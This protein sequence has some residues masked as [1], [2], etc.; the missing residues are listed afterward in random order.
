VVVGAEQPHAQRQDRRIRVGRIIG[1]ITEGAITYDRYV[2]GAAEVRI[3]QGV[4]VSFP[5]R[6][7][8]TFLKPSQ[9]VIVQGDAAAIGFLAH[10]P[11]AG[12]GAA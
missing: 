10:S 1:T 8:L 2:D 6:F 3:A 4:A 9:G 7:D 5:A 12:Q 11:L